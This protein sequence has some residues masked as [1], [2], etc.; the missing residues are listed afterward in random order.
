MV[1]ASLLYTTTGM[2]Q[3][4]LIATLTH[5]DEISTYYGVGAFQSAHSAAKS[6]DIITLS[7]GTFTGFTITKAVIVRGAG[8]DA[9]VPTQISS[10]MSINIPES[11]TCRFSIEGVRFAAGSLLLYGSCTKPYFIKCKF[12][13]VL[14]YDTSYNYYASSIKDAMFVNCWLGNELIIAGSTTAK[15]SHCYVY[16]YHNE[17]DYSS[18]AQFINCI[19]RGYLQNFCRSTFVNSI[20]WGCGNSYYGLPSLPAETVAMNCTAFNFYNGAYLNSNIYSKMQGSQ[21][22]CTTSK[23][24]ELFKN[25]DTFELNDEA[26]A[27]FLGTDGTEIGLY[28]GQ[29]PYNTI[30]AYPRITKLNVA[31]QSTA[32][33]KLSVEIEVS[34]AE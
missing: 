5:G 11:D 4:K 27:K 9:T 8:T 25:T 1:V 21:V 29:Y 14:F 33:D 22:D 20:I 16:S 32:D 10:D 17:Q 15:F 13:N 30:P 3:T 6:G 31:K 7:G 19:V 24:G 12:G 26:K 28:G 34:A 18:K 23:T 2:A